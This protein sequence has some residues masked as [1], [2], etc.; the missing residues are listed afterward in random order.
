MCAETVL[1]V[2][3]LHVHFAVRRGRFGRKSIRTV[4]AVNGVSFTVARGE[5]FGIVGESGSGKSTLASAIVR[6]LRPTQGRIAVGGQDVT[7]LR[8]AALRSLR[9]D[10]QMVFQDTKSSL[11]PYLK[12][13]QIIR[14]PLVTHGLQSDRRTIL[15]IL[16]RVGLGEA[17]VDRYPHQLS[18]GQRQRIG[19]ARAIALSPR[20][21]VADE[22]VSALDVSIQ[23][24]ILNLLRSLRTDLGLSFVLISHDIA[25]VSFFCQRVGVM[26][27]GRMV[28]IGPTRSV[29]REPGHPYT[30]ALIAAV[31]GHFRTQ[32]AERVILRGE[33]PDPASPPRG[34]AF[35]TRCPVKIG[36]ICET[37]LPP[38]YPT[39]DGGW[40]ACHLLAD[41]ASTTK[42]HQERS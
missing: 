31:P 37:Q 39:V 16:T 6:L 25:V 36:A 41:A 2:D 13:E 3:N 27:L 26:Y 1:D 33:V 12:V 10:L 28:E 29:M 35:H 21:I 20:L 23:A 40:A 11:N 38:A 15:E 19:I 5:A 24:Q 22:P 9:R 7:S 32:A 18:G 8:E 34:C 17:H 30:K 14:E 42:S 4:K